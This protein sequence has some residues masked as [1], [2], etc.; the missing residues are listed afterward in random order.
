MFR[1]KHLNH[2]VVVSLRLLA[3]QAVAQDC[4]RSCVE[5]RSQR[6]DVPSLVE[7]RVAVPLRD[8]LVIAL[9]SDGLGMD[10]ALERSAQR[11]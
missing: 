6:E 4:Q 5:W 9:L 10:L 3:K 8:V 2:I 7:L 11:R 1:S